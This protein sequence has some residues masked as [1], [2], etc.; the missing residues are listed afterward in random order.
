MF[1][2]NVPRLPV[3]GRTYREKYQTILKGSIKAEIK[4]HLPNDG[5][6]FQQKFAPCQT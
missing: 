2:H 5:R 1:P 6:V 3:T 4:K